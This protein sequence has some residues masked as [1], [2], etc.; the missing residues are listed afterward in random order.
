MDDRRRLFERVYSREGAE[1]EPREYRDPQTGATVRMTPSQWALA[2][3][4]RLHPQAPADDEKAPEHRGARGRADPDAPSAGDDGGGGFDDFD[5]AH[6]D[7]EESD[8]EADARGT[9]VASRM[10]RAA[11][12]L[13][14]AA[15]FVLGVLVAVGITTAVGRTAPSA[16]VAAS[17]PTS[18][19]NDEDWHPVPGPAVREFLNSSPRATDLPAAVTDGFVPTSFHLIAG[20]VSLQESA[21]IY[22]AER[23]SDQ[24]CLVAVANG[25]RVAETCATLPE[26]AVHG[27]TLTKD[28]VRDVDGLPVAVTVTWSTD[29]TISWEAMPSVG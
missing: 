20:S 1:E 16:P 8:D 17:T 6:F 27:L 2:E 25:A 12:V 15:A 13:V 10:R 3:Y 4:D 28:A 26:M 21:S 18:A 24:Y 5:R 23:L 29:G 7:Q 22:A 11:P 19:P 9:G 14:A